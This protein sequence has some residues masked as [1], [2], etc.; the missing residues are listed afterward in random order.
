M[1]ILLVQQPQQAVPVGRIAGGEFR[2]RGQVEFAADGSA[3]LLSGA[4]VEVRAGTA[5]LALAGGEARFCGPLKVTVLKGA[6]GDAPLLFALDSSE[7]GSF[8]L[9][10]SGATSHTV[11]TP[12]FSVAAVPAADGAARKLAVR[13][14]ANGDTCVAALAGSLRVR[15]QLGPAEMLIPPGKAMLV[16]AAGVEKA[17]GAEA[18]A[19]SCGA[20]PVRAASPAPVS[21]PAATT[22]T[23]TTIAAAPLVYQADPRGPASASN[24]PMKEAEVTLPVVVAGSKPAADAPETAPPAAPAPKPQRLS[25]GAKLKRFFRALFGG[26]AQA[27]GAGA[28]RT[29]HIRVDR[30]AARCKAWA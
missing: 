22:E 28:R 29:S 24:P 9:E 15:E 10:Y 3:L 13:L 16:P 19:C 12:F 5:R 23:K 14:A 30:A 26:S 20:P 11:Q 4:E 2:V 1:L 21:G 7:A 6:P 25:L 27:K 17:T 8:E 18:S